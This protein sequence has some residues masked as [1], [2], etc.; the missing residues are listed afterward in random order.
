MSSF[1]F[2]HE[3][4][5]SGQGLPYP[6]KLKL[7]TKPVNQEGARTTKPGEAFLSHDLLQLDET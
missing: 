1:L 3:A 7:Q 2:L 6:G 5:Q 4:K